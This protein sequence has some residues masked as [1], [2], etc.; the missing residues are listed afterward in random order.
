MVSLTS[1]AEWHAISKGNCML[2]TPRLFAGV[3]LAL[4]P[5]LI[6]E[7]SWRSKW[8]QS[9]NRFGVDEPYLIGSREE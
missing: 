2:V 6:L 7:L 4:E 8:I 3:L 1:R 9:M 5:D